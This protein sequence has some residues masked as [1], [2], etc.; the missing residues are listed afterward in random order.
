MSLGL[1][2]RVYM[3][4]VLLSKRPPNPGQNTATIMQEW[5]ERD[6]QKKRKQIYIGIW[7]SVKKKHLRHIKAR[8][9]A[10]N[11]SS[12]NARHAT[13]ISS[14]SYD[15]I[16]QA[17]TRSPPTSHT[18]SLS[19]ALSPY[20]SSCSFFS[21]LSEKNFVHLWQCSGKAALLLYASMTGTH[22]DRLSW[23]LG[24]ARVCILIPQTPRR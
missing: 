9:V 8:S 7:G 20:R 16:Y 24:F 3:G 6:N 2:V 5:T 21:L 1:H 11:Q 15:F 19:L 13:L 14:L 12:F 22:V 4:A 17:H 10:T 23:A 18:L